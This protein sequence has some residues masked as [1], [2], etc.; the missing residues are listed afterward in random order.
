MEKYAI[1][2]GYIEELSKRFYLDNAV[3]KSSESV[4]S[5]TYIFNMK[6]IDTHFNSEQNQFLH[7]DSEKILSSP[8]YKLLDL[9]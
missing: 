5:E 7:L 3:L 9:N 4:L 8:L 6:M 1:Q 2:E